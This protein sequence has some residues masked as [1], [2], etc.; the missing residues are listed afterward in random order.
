MGVKLGGGSG[1]Q[2]ENGVWVVGC[3]VDMRQVGMS[4]RV[5]PS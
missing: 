4:L 3:N 5:T 2:T 1:V